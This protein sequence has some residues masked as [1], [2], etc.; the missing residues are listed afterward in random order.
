[1]LTTLIALALGLQGGVQQTI[2]TDKSSGGRLMY[3]ERLDRLAQPFYSHKTFGD[4]GQKWEFDWQVAGYVKNPAIDAFDLRFRVF[5]QEHKSIGDPSVPVT[6]ELLR[7]WDF[8]YQRLK[9]DHTARM[10][11]FVD[12][13]LCW[14]GKPGGEQVFE[15]SDEGGEQRLVNSIYIY[16][17]ASFTDPVEM[18]REV[19]H[20]YGHAVLPPV[21]GFKEPEDWANGYLGEK[22]FLTWLRDAE[23]SGAL[24]PADAMGATE[25]QLNA[26]VKKNVDPLVLKIAEHGP[27]LALLSKSGPEAMNEYLGLAL[28]AATVLPESVFA[29]SLALIGSTSAKDYPEAVMLASEEPERLVLHI[30]NNLKKQPIWI[31]LGKGH[32]G[33]ASLMARAGNWAK[34]QPS[35]GVVTVLPAQGG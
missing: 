5:S 3:Q 17:I 26:W 33:G 21:G 19:A 23:A 10:Q 14:G 32:L 18:A 30:P 27:D 16:D 20:E 6:R 15:Q 9:R 8:V 11:R 24:A 29:R 1:M 31:P 28:Y 35:Q 22:L 13:F 2:L 7:L 4:P 25:P 12:V 34:V